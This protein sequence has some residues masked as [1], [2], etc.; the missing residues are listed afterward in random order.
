MQFQKNNTQQKFENKHYLPIYFNQVLN[1]DQINMIH[2]IAKT[3][4]FV[5]AQTGGGEDGNVNLGVRRSTV[6]W[7]D[8][9]KIDKSIL[10]FFQ[11]L[12]IEANELGF[13]FDLS[14]YETIQYTVY[15]ESNAGEY[16]WHTDTMFLQNNEVRKLSMSLLLSD[17]SEFEGGKLLLN[18]DGNIVVAEER[19]GRAFF[20][21][22]WMP[23]CV[24]P[25]IKGTR[26]SLVIWAHG[27]RFK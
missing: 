23:H 12:F 10:E 16:K 19:K 14:G 13:K 11:N 5:P 9:N 27:P 25:V 21:P 2:E 26:K 7:L 20:F 1:D 18:P 24:T 22:S 3:N 15:E 8:F 4:S 17:P 6:A